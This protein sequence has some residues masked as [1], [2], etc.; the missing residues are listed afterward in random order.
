MSEIRNAMGSVMNTKSSSIF[1]ITIYFKCPC[2]W[3][4][5][6]K[7]ERSIKILDRLHKKTCA[8]WREKNACKSFSIKADKT[9]AISGKKTE[10]ERHKKVKLGDTPTP[11]LLNGV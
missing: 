8:V 7:E 9:D 11:P 10:Y 2:G 3:C 5:T 4:I 6:T 1:E